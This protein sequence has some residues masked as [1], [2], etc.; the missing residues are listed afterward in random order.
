MCTT[1]YVQ[2]WYLFS[3]K[4]ETWSDY[5]QQ[6]ASLRGDARQLSVKHRGDLDLETMRMDICIHIYVYIYIYIRIYT[7]TQ[8]YIYTY[9]ILIYIYV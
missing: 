2:L 9:H 3:R 5:C 8:L 1:P 6:H 7:Y 4:T